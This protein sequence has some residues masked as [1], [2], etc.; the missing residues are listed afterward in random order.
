[1]SRSA[2]ALLAVL[3]GACASVHAS[4]I[5]AL[6]NSGVYD[7]GK[8]NS[9]GNLDVHYEVRYSDGTWN[10]A[11]VV[12]GESVPDPGHYPIS[13]GTWFGWGAE[14]SPFSRW[15]SYQ[16]DQAVLATVGTYVYRT[17]FDLTGLNP[18][19]AVIQG[20]WS[21]DNT[22]LDILI[23]GTS[24]GNTIPHGGIGTETYWQF[25][26]FSVTS[27]FVHGINTLEFVVFNFPP[28]GPLNATG[29]RVEMSGTAA[30]PEPATMPLIG[31]ALFVIGGMRL[32]RRRR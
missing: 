30:V 20:R 15:I 28:G 14:D 1:M 27:G 23:N 31:S 18:N 16:A 21:T 5:P 22:G 17:T 13:P 32:L 29:L 9:G 26:T 3:I 19:T 11:Y 2:Y 10:P 8:L 25:T 24:T 6:Y 4:P 12:I 7:D